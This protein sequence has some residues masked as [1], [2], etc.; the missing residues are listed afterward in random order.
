MTG[1]KGKSQNSY[2]NVD[3]CNVEINSV[4]VSTGYT[5]FGVY[6]GQSEEPASAKS[7]HYIVSIGSMVGGASIAL[8]AVVAVVVAIVHHRRRKQDLANCDAD[9][10][11]IAL[12]N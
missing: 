10:M 2:S 4:N 3:K 11:Y 6:I 7:F 9:D 5:I 12:I 8:V 1:F